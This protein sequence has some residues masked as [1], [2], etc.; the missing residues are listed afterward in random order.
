MG[1]C[2]R[3]QAGDDSHLPVVPAGNLRMPCPVALAELRRVTPAST[4][5]WLGLL[6]E[7]ELRGQG[8]LTP[9]TGDKGTI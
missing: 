9:R 1:Y 6:L 4:V 2:K 8:P 5:R 3:L 7:R